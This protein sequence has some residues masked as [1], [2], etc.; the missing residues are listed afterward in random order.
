MRGFPCA[1]QRFF[2]S[3]SS[4]PFN[5][6][7]GGLRFRI[8]THWTMTPRRSKPGSLGPHVPIMT[9]HL[10]FLQARLPI[11]TATSHFFRVPSHCTLDLIRSTLIVSTILPRRDGVATNCREIRKTSTSSLYTALRRSFFRP[12]PGMNLFFKIYS[13]LSFSLQWP[14]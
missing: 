2:P 4:K 6:L 9:P 1:I 14:L 13:V 8:F 3:Q 12:F 7:S 11:L 5:S 10:P